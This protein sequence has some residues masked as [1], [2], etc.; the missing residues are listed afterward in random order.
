[1]LNKNVAFQDWGLLDY[2]EAWDRQELLFKE[3]IAKKTANRTDGTELPTDN[4][5]VFVEHPHVYTL[6]KSGKASHL[7]LDE[8]GL[9]EK[10]ARYY[11]INRGG[12]STGAINSSV[13]TSSAAESSIVPAP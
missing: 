1:M 11:K 9:E 5:L 4:F 13:P 3:I 8:H 10:K 12:C 6:G 7:L 2:Q